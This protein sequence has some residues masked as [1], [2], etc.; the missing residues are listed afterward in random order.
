MERAAIAER[1][2]PAETRRLLALAWPVALT[3]LNWTILQVTDVVVVGLVSTE[4]AAALGASRALTFVGIVGALG[5]LT[6]ILVYAARA[7]GAGDLRATGRVFHEGLVLGLILG[8]VSGG[9]LFAFAEPLLLAIG[10][11]PRIAPDAAAV[12]RVMALAYPFQ[13]LSIAS[14][15]FLEGVSR[16]RRVAAVN[17]AT[18][19]INGVLAWAMSGGHLGLPQMGAVGAAGATP[20]GDL[21][22]DPGDR[23]RAR[24]RRFRDPDRAVDAVG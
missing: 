23:L 24:T 22:P 15:F 12:V 7:D 11:S 1:N 9:I 19:P 20:A 4:Q 18:L 6:G 5:W 13:T 10:V 3:S 17:I 21:W 2:V 8:L 16:P 14:S